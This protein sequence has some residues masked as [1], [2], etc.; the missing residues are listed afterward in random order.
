MAGTDHDFAAL[1]ARARSGEQAAQGELL[2]PLREFLRM[3]AARQFDAR[4]SGRIDTSDIVHETYI[5]ALESLEQFRGSQRPEF[6]A[7]LRTVHEHVVQNLAREHIVTQKRSVRREQPLTAGDLPQLHA[8]IESTPSGNLLQAEAILQ[9][10]Q[11]LDKLPADQRTAIRL[12]YFENWTVERIGNHMQRS[13][14]AIAGLLKRGLKSLRV[15]LSP[16]SV[17]ST[18]P[19]GTEESRS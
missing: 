11:A 10:I 14:P 15:R 12:R 2:E 3:L 7:W 8:L 6:L 13:L 19:T 16:T 4:L 5:T 1:L 17:D 18:S 9:L